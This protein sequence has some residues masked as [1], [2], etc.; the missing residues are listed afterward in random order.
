[1]NMQPEVVQEIVNSY[2]E[3]VKKLED[4]SDRFSKADQDFSSWTGPTRQRLQENIQKEMPAFNELIEVVLSYGNTA[5]ETADR[6]IEVENDLKK[7]LG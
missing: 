1:M 7:M 2:I 5:Q 3:E 6:T 4:C